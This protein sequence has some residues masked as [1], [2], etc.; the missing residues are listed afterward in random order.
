MDEAKTL[1]SQVKALT[2]INHHEKFDWE[3]T[4]KVQG[5]FELKMSVFLWFKKESL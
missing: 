3:M 4:D 1:V 5:F 2:P